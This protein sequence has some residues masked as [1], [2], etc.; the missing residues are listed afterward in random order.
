MKKRSR[1]AVSL[2]LEAMELQKQWICKQMHA[3]VSMSNVAA[4]DV[5]LHSN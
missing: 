4:P 3:L 2:A 1:C 5:L